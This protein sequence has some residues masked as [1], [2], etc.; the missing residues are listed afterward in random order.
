MKFLTVLC[1][2]LFSISILS[3][4]LKYPQLSAKDLGGGPEAKI[5]D[6]INVIYKAINVWCER[7]TDLYIKEFLLSNNIKEDRFIRDTVLKSFEK[8]VEELSEAEV[9]QLVIVDSSHKMLTVLD[10]YADVLYARNLVN[11]TRDLDALEI[12]KLSRRVD[13]VSREL[14]ELVKAKVSVHGVTARE[15]VNVKWMYFFQG[16]NFVIMMVLFLKI[17]CLQK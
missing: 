13:V 14:A 12:K 5:T 16:I 7:F 1:C 3:S 11:K 4:E 17:K 6:D 10:G 8:F 9:R 2:L 15:S